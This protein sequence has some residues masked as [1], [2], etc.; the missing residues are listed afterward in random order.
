MGMRGA[1]IASFAGKSILGKSRTSE[2][3]N[4]LESRIYTTL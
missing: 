3:E 1:Q 2:R 4:K